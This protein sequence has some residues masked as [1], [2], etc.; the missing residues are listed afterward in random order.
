MSDSNL[1]SKSNFEIFESILRW[2][3]NTN[4]YFSFM[5]KFKL[6]WIMLHFMCMDIGPVYKERQTDHMDR[7]L[8]SKI[9]KALK[10]MHKKTSSALS[11]I[12]VIIAV[13]F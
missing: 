9:I 1:F 12:Q 8:W 13:I 10:K 7:I 6:L 4:F 2:L 3:Q 11:A 5:D